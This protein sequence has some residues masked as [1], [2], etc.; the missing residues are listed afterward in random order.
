MSPSV[1]EPVI[2][3]PK[4]CTS[5][6]TLCLAHIGTDCLHCAPPPVTTQRPLWEGSH[7]F[8]S[9]PTLIWDSFA[10]SRERCRN[11]TGML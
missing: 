11:I 2:L 3:Q 10:A 4:G 8:R 5:N 9:L 1:S 7:I 6:S